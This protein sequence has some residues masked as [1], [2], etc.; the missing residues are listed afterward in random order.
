MF[1]FRYNV[2]AHAARHRGNLVD[3]RTRQ[4]NT[5]TV[6]D[7]QEALPIHHKGFRMGDFAFVDGFVT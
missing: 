5:F 7:C 2:T 1:L 4:W 6:D 3:P